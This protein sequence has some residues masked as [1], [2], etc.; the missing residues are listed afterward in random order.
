[1]TEDVPYGL[2]VTVV[3]GRLV[4]RPATLHEAGIRLFSAMYDQEFALENEFLHALELESYSLCDL[5]HASRT[6]VLHR[7]SKPQ[8]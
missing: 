4:E 2:Q 5:Q 6:G 3:L 1:M 7:L 8:T